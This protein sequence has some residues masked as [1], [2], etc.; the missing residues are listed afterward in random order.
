MASSKSNPQTVAT[1]R[2]R[3]KA[4]I[5]SKKFNLHESLIKDYERACKKCG[6][7]QAEKIK[8]LMKGFIAEVDGN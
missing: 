5:K 2:Y 7:S 6:V 1:E 8:E 3:K 4:G